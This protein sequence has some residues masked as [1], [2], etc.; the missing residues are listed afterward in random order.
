MTIGRS[1]ANER[2][3]AALIAIHDL[4]L[5][6]RFSD[7]LVLLGDGKVRVQGGWKDVLIRS[8]LEAV[9]GVSALVGTDQNLPYVIPTRCT[10]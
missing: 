2:G 6:S 1:V 10:D 7:R 9:Y 3:I 8:H 5:A 4:A